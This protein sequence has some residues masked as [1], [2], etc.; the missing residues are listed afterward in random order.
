MTYGVVGNE[1]HC[2][3]RIRIEGRVHETSDHARIFNDTL[4]LTLMRR[5]HEPDMKNSPNLK[6][7]T[8]MDAGHVE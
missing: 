6:R 2:D 3:L 7:Y 1:I 4:F 5:K 8:G